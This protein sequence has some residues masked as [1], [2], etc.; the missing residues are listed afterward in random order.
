MSPK[1]RAKAV[2]AA[3]AA[4]GTG[5]APAAAQL[6]KTY[7]AEKLTGARAVR[8]KHPT[9]GSPNY[10]YEVKWVGYATRENT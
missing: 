1:K 5:A 10:V 3:A 2:A 4:A 8:G 9:T 6:R 7:T